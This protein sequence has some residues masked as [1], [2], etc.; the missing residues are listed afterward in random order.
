MTDAA[1][2]AILLCCL[3]CGWFGAWMAESIL[4]VGGVSI[5]DYLVGSER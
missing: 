4:N 2:Q 3:E 5:M 1:F